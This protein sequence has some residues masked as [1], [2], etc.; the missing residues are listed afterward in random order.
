MPRGLGCQPGGR[1]SAGFTSS[2]GN[3]RQLGNRRRYLLT[4]HHEPSPPPGQQVALGIVN[5]S[6]ANPAAACWRMWISPT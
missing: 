6:D 3:L 4:D 1:A 5:L 2:P